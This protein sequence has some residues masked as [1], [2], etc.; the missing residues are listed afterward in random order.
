M[1]IIWQCD[2]ANEHAGWAGGLEIA[3]GR[4]SYF[5]TPEL[6]WTLCYCP[7]QTSWRKGKK[8]EATGMNTSHQQLMKWNEV[9]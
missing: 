9:G 6:F 8:I 4:L 2:F 7:S 5:G 1:V 3:Q